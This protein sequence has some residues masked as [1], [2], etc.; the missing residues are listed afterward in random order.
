MDRQIRPIMSQSPI[1]SSVTDFGV[2]TSGSAM[3]PPL[4]FQD[5]TGTATTGALTFTTSSSWSTEDKAAFIT[6]WK[7]LRLELLPLLLK[8]EY[9]PI[10]GMQM[11]RI[12]DPKTH[13][14]VVT[15]TLTYEPIN[16]P[17]KGV[18]KTL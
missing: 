13:K 6:E 15:L 18:R 5:I 16:A 9:W 1:Q 14:T 2:N 7:K 10:K 4:D 3:P 17:V 8:D 12:M 11:N